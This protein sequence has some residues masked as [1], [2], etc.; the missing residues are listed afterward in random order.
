VERKYQNQKKAIIA[1]AIACALVLAL[2]V[3]FQVR[4]QN[5]KAEQVDI[6]EAQVGELTAQRDEMQA[7]YDAKD[8]KN[9]LDAM[10]D[11][12]ASLKDQKTE[13]L[14]TPEPTAE[15]TDEPTPE[16]SPEPT[17]EPTPTAAPQG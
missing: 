5:V 12:I 10:K 15:P 14:K 16:P 7:A 4:I 6:Y 1:L 2:I 3:Y 17:A 11:E 9:T 13:L 8:Y